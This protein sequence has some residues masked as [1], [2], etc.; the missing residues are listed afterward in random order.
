MG[1]T[2][3]WKQ[4]I[5]ETERKV[6]KTITALSSLGNSAWGVKMREMRTIYNGVALPQMMYACSAWS[7]AN[8]GGKGYTK[9]TLNRLQ[10]LQARAARAMSG[11]FRV[12]SFPALDVEVHLLPVEQQ[13]WKHNGTINRMSPGAQH[14]S[15][16]EGGPNRRKKTSPRQA[17]EQE[18]LN[19]Q[20]P[21]IRPR[22][23]IGPFVTP[24]W[25]QGPRMYIADTAETAREDHR[26]CV[27][28]D[29]NAIHI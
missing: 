11:A 21:D 5:D 23:Q 14:R 18:L 27:E 24:P 20:G 17:I 8:W 12:T 29:T 25:W 26:R 1:S 28:H 4:H 9:R 2:L 19:R 6:S 15:G 22:E 16:S 3:R 13:I 7:N 10:R